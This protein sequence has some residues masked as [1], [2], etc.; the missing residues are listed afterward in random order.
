MRRTAARLTL[1]ALLGAPVGLPATQETPP[2]FP[3]ESARVTVDVVV[4]DRQGR[5]VTD[6]TAADFEVLEDGVPQ[7]V[8][9]F[10]PAVLPS[11]EASGAAGQMV[12]S[13]DGRGD[14]ATPTAADA[15]SGHAAIALVFDRLS[16][17]GRVA[18]QEA[19]RDLV[20]H[21]R[22]RAMQSACS[23]SRARSSFCRT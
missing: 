14:E 13:A 16:T 22:G 21:G 12:L 10:V 7:R 6:L 3:V 4:H 5:P 20:E 2:Q 8:D 23:R 17:Q 15:P 1:V 19:A 9:Q 11:P 18:A